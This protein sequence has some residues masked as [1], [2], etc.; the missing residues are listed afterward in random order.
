MRNKGRRKFQ[1]PSSLRGGGN[2]EPDRPDIEYKERR[3]I[4]EETT[5]T[6]STLGEANTAQ[7]HPRSPDSTENLGRRRRSIGDVP[8]PQENAEH[9]RRSKRRK[10]AS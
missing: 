10:K 9:V 3:R 6:S 4:D 8:A 2:D 1:T 5:Q 7:K